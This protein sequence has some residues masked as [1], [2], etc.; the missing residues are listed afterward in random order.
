MCSLSARGTA[1]TLG[2]LGGE[3]VYS[4]AKNLRK[5]PRNPRGL[6][7]APRSW[8]EARSLLLVRGLQIFT[9]TIEILH[10]RPAQADR[11]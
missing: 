7:P 5:N 11:A 8:Y 3:N 1:P 10:E 9:K 2:P 4:A 6:K